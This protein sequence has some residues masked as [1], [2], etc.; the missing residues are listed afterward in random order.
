MGNTIEITTE[1]SCL[2]HVGHGFIPPSTRVHN[3]S[4]E[5]IKPC[6]G[7]ITYMPKRFQ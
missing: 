5:N 6:T 3:H 1:Y 7:I 4:R 2:E